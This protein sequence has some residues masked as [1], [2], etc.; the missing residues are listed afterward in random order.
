MKDDNA[1]TTEPTLLALQ[2]SQSAFDQTRGLDF[3]H[4][5]PAAGPGETAAPEALLRQI[6]FVV[7]ALCGETGELANI[8]KKIRRATWIDGQP[9][10]LPPNVTREI[11]DILAYLLKLGNVLGKGLDEVYLERLCTNF[12]RFPVR[13]PQEGEPAANVLVVAGPA[14]SGKSTVAKALSRDFQTY[15]E[16]EKNNPHLDGNLLGETKLD[17]FESQQW[18]IHQLEAFL[19]KANSHEH[20]V[21]DQEPVA[22]TQVYAKFLLEG[23]RLS[24]PQYVTLMKRTA[25]LELRLSQWSGGRTVLLLDASP[26]VL[27]RRLSERTYGPRWTR[28]QVGRIHELFQELKDQIGRVIVLRTDELAE[29]E[30]LDVA[31]NLLLS[32]PE[33]RT[34]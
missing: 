8:V 28:S 16:T 10:A 3:L 33:R 5:L 1:S 30:V 20:V 21:L 4:R 19:G 13:A 34:V 14:G 27:F 32:R 31:R 2:A 17:A 7:L 6:E 15:I 9:A 18:F 22:I 25:D 23:G 11:G 26:D 12:L 29:S 24:G